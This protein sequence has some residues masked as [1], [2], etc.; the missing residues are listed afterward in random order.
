MRRKSR[1]LFL[2]KQDLRVLAAL[3]YMGKKI[4]V[5]PNVNSWSEKAKSAVAVTVSRGVE[6]RCDAA[7]ICNHILGQTP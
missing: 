2:S 4:V 6:F 5:H 3:K 1:L 7:T